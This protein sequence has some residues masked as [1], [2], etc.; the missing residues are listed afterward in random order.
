MPF[1]ELLRLSMAS[2]YHERH[3]CH[4]ESHQRYLTNINA[5]TAWPASCRPKNVVITVRA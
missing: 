4:D 5:F 3:Q 1:T 2:D